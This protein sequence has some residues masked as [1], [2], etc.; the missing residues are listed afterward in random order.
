VELECASGDADSPAHKSAARELTERV[1]V[2]RAAAVD[3]AYLVYASERGYEA[4]MK[5]VETAALPV[6]DALVAISGSELYQRGYRSPDPLWDQMLRKEWDPKPSTWVI[7]KFF[8]NDLAES[9]TKEEEYELVFDLKKEASSSAVELRD[10][11]QE[12]LAELG[13]KARVSLRGGS[14]GSLAI[15]PAS[16]DI[17]KV[18]SFC[19]KMLKIEDPGSTCVFGRAGFVD[20]CIGSREDAVGVVAACDSLPESLQTAKEDGRVFVSQ[21]KGI[22]A[23]LDGVMHHAVF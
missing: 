5:T 17:G 1:Q 18:V 12:K 3:S 13:I 22:P 23:L 10:Q 15:M 11:V 7:N 20:S 16:G 4:A 8:P 21:L 14:E 9:D 2:D 19:A 6:P